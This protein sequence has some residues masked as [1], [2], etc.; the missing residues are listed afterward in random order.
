VSWEPVWESAEGFT[1][2][3]VSPDFAVDGRVCAV[4][5]EALSCSDDGGLSWARTSIPAHTFRISVG[6]EHRV[7]ATVRGEGLY[8][9]PDDGGSWSLA[10]FDGDDITAIAELAG[11]VVLVAKADE[12]EWRSD[13]GG[14]SWA[15]V[16]VLKVEPDQ[17]RD[18]VNFF[19]FVEGPDGAVYMTCWY[20]LARSDDGGSTYTFYNIE[21]I[22]N[23]HSVVLTEG[24]DGA[25]SAWVGTYGGGPLLV[26]IHSLATQEFP[27]LTKR[28]TRNTP[29]TTSWDRDGTAIFDEGYCTWRTTDQGD[30]WDRIA[31]DPNVDRQMEMEQDVKGVALAPNTSDD[32]FVLTTNGQAAMSFLVSEDL[33]DTW[34][35]GTQD[36]VCAT[37]GFAVALSPRWPDESRAWA[38]CGGAIYQ[39]VDRGQSWSVL[40]DTGASFVFRIAEQMDGSLLIATSDGLWRM[41]EASTSQIAFSGALVTGVAA[42]T[43]DGDDTVFALV[44]TVGWHR[45]DDGGQSWVTLPAPTGDV[46]RMVSMSPG[47]AEDGSVAVAGYGGAWASTDRGDSWFSIYTL[48]V[49]ESSHAAWAAT[50]TWTAADWHGASSGEVMVTDEV[51]ASRTLDFR[52]IAVAV[53]APPASGCR[54]PEHGVVAISLDGGPAEEVTI[55]DATIWSADALSDTWHT[56]RIEAVSGTVTLDDVRVTRIA[57]P[58]RS[59]SCGQSGPAAMLLLPLVLVRRRRGARV[60]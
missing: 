17:S 53:E 33:G 57:V 22:Q 25:L 4:E 35:T 28:Y 10:G 56:I 1:D 45:S 15:Y 13:D 42:S 50:G 7:W 36:P 29:T 54:S 51:G 16:D 34:T 19:Y 49:Y 60:A 9:S 47:F 21:P 24:A 59:C 43:Q 31:Q 48:E 14:A 30:T 23:T 20:G 3:D 26:D 41:D 44:P 2:V 12:A 37:D 6:A 58:E 27:S 46:P 38:A 52:G 18:G 39:S 40:G 8:L 5:S 55:R 11:D 32:A